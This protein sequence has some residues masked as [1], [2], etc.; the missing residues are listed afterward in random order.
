MNTISRRWRRR[1]GAK[2]QRRERRRDL[3]VQLTTNDNGTFLQ[4]TPLMGLAPSRPVD[5]SYTTGKNAAVL[6]RHLVVGRQIPKRPEGRLSLPAPSPVSITTT[7]GFLPQ[8]IKRRQIFLNSFNVGGLERRS[9][10]ESKASVNILR[11]KSGGLRDNQCGALPVIHQPAT[12]TSC[13][14]GR[15]CYRCRSSA[16]KQGLVCAFTASES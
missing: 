9:Y 7:G 4:A 10:S 16:T 14:C 3:E 12:A 2:I 8:L 13:T 11:L 5:D 15:S 1:Q 6:H